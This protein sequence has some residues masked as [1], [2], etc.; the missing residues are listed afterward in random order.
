MRWTGAII[1]LPEACSRV[2]LRI[3]QYNLSFSLQII[4]F[5]LYLLF[6]IIHP[7]IR[8]TKTKEYCWDETAFSL[9]FL[10]TNS[11]TDPNCRASPYVLSR[12][13]MAFFREWLRALSL[14][15]CSEWL[16]EGASLPLLGLWQESWFLTHTHSLSAQHAFFK[17]K[18]DA[19]GH[20]VRNME[21]TV[22]LHHFER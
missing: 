5:Y 12:K 13:E 15:S 3:L 1:V 9:P 18:W 8:T 22:I 6:W 16:W 7:E 2:L 19:W 14:G 20:T 11:C 17:R 4:L 10:C 21:H